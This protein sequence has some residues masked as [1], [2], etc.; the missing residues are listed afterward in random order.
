MRP[1]QLKTT[2][3]QKGERKKE[4]ES[5]GC[6]PEEALS[7]AGPQP[8][9]PS[10]HFICCHRDSRGEWGGP[11]SKSQPRTGNATEPAPQGPPAFPG[12]PSGGVA[13]FS[14]NRT[15]NP[16]ILKADAPISTLGSL[17]RG[18]IPRTSAD[19]IGSYS[20]NLPRLPVANDSLQAWCPNHPHPG[21][22]WRFGKAVGRNSHNF[23]F[24]PV[25]AG[26]LR[27]P[28]DPAARF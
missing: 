14:F 26:H 7:P 11:G 28:Q 20:Q 12:G 15:L 24:L 17:C 3:L 23:Y 19:P 18:S 5:T 2:N 8:G 6:C 25:A 10:L 27:G 13:H 22:S 1:I 9:L 21:H 4:S 16:P